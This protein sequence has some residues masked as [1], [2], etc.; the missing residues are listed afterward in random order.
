MKKSL[1]S[2]FAY[3]TLI[4]G[5]AQN[6]SP[7]Y[8]KWKIIHTSETE[9]DFVRIKKEDENTMGN[10]GHFIE[11]YEA[12][13]YHENASAPCG[14]DDNRFR[15]QGKWS[16]DSKNKTIELKDIVVNSARPNIYNIYKVLTSGTIQVLFAK[17]DELKTKVVK[18]WE[19]VRAKK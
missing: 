13:T 12:G 10:W 14:L 18:P 1:F 15:Y 6:N 16:Y 9:N 11:F 7:L 17:P 2:I 4:N 8:G 19:T 5:I 3:L